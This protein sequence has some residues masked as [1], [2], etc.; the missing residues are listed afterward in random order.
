MLFARLVKW[1]CAVAAISALALPM[2][3]KAEPI[4]LKGITSWIATYPHSQSYFIFQSK[5]NKALQ[6]KLVISYLGGAEVVPAVEQ[7]E[8][9][10]DGVV[11]VL[12]T[13]GAYYKGQ[14]PEAAAMLGSSKYPS[15][16]RKNG[17]YDIV[18]Q[19]HKQHGVV[20]LAMVGGTRGD[21]YRCYLA[22]KKINRA[23][24]SGLKLRVSSTYIEL[25]KA[26]GGTPVRMKPTD[27][28]TA[29][30]RGVVDGFCW[31]YLGIRDYAFPEVSKYVINTPFY[32]I[33]TAILINQ[34]AWNGLPADMRTTIEK[35]APEVEK[36][37]EKFINALNADEDTALKAAGMQFIEFNATEA[38]K[39]RDA[40]NDAHWKWLIG[41]SPVLGPKLKALAN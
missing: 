5:V 6:G 12:M 24:L 28:Y 33:D 41:K 36:D 11:D 7:F 25:V 9:V 15:A 38:Q 23:D 37:V 3:A 1:S 8:A 31:S 13:A 14:V 20:Y 30:E 34:A 16:L 22:K 19:A 26:L 17:Y 27:V 39:Y 40:A 18:R 4:V 35:I 10:R 29:L 21:G 32:N 2:A